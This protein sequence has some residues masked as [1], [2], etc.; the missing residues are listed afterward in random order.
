MQA[1]AWDQEKTGASAHAKQKSGKNKFFFSAFMF[2]S[3]PQQIIKWCPPT[4]E[5]T[6]CF[7][8]STAN[9]N[10]NLFQKHPHRHT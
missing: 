3:E 6:I 5:G 7:T 8:Q 10:T 2:Y 9:S 4:L 1:L